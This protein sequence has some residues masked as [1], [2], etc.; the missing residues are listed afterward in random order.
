MQDIYGKNK[1]YISWSS[2]NLWKTSRNSYRKRYYDG[3][4]IPK[5][6]EMIF[7]SKI[8][9]LLEENNKEYRH[10]PRYEIPE[11]KIYLEIAPGIKIMAYI[12]SYDPE[13]CAFIE[14]K[15]GHKNP[16]GQDTWN[17]L[18]VMRHEQL[19]FYSLAIQEE[20]KR[21]QEQ[22]QLV[23]LET[24]VGDG[25]VN[26]KGHQLETGK[27]LKLIGEPKVFYRTIEQWERDLMKENILKV[28]EEIKEDYKNYL[29]F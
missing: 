20:N 11:H 6:P 23:Y 18:K 13:S 9:R 7:G 3:I 19:D 16:K 25:I 2:Y 24:E 28:A 15:T 17:Q 12:D 4:P 29:P 10:I 27:K 22:C 1:D 5:T 21:I 26:Y 14:Y 8:G